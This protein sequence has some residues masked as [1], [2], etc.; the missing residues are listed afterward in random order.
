VENVFVGHG[1]IFRGEK[2]EVANAMRCIDGA[3]RPVADVVPAVAGGAKDQDIGVVMFGEVALDRLVCAFRVTDEDRQFATDH[4]IEPLPNLGREPGETSRT[5][6]EDLFIR[7]AF[8]S[9]R[10][11][12]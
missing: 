9:A 5:G 12:R 8:S 10:M 11:H 2:R 3:D 4:L 6:E 1:G 7:V